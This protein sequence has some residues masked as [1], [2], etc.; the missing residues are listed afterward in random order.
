LTEKYET[1]LA[2]DENY[3]VKTIPFG[4]KTYHDK[5]GK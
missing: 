2:G 3:F 5:S 4:R 1:I